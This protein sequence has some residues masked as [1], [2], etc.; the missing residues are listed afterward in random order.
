MKKYVSR[1]TKWLGIIALLCGIAVLVG[2]ILAFANTS[3]TS[4]VMIAL[5]GMFGILFLSCFLAEKSRAL[6]K[7]RQDITQIL[8]VKTAD[9]SLKQ[10]ISQARIKAMFSGG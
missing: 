3:M 1:A 2:I 8:F 9:F 4:F 6:I 5:G 10:T 7:C